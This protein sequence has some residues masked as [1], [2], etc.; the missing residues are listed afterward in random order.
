[1]GDDAPGTVALCCHSPLDKSRLRYFLRIPGTRLQIDIWSCW[2]RYRQQEHPLLSA[3]Q[4]RQGTL[5]KRCCCSIAVIRSHHSLQTLLLARGAIAQWACRRDDAIDDSAIHTLVDLHRQTRVH[6]HL[7]LAMQSMR[8]LRM[9]MS[10]GMRSA[11]TA[12]G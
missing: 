5:T 6:H 8:I 10:K 3:F 9:W 11:S 4:S 7:A 1:M 12:L 2:R